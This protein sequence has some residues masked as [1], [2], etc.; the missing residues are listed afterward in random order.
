MGVEDS[1][2]EVGMEQDQNGSMVHVALQ[3]SP[4]IVFPSSQVSPRFKMP[5]PHKDGDGVSTRMFWPVSED[6]TGVLEEEDCTGVL[7]EDDW[8]GVLGEEEM[9]GVL[10]EEDWTG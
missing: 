4:D 5:F 8:S 6:W 9:I 1:N 10:E 7:E 3:P 2:D